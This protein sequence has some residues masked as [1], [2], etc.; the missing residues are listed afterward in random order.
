MRKKIKDFAEAM[1]EVMQKHD[2]EKRNS[3][4][5]MQLHTLEHLL[6][7]EVREWNANRL[8]HI[9]GVNHPKEKEVIDIAN[10]AMMLWY[11]YKNE[12]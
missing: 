4:K 3:W 7:S 5:S 10:I 12:K 2:A 11:R 8:G 9:D 6:L 1:E